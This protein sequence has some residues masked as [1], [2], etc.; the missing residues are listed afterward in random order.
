M[1][2]KMKT[3]SH[4]G[5]CESCR[6][7]ENRETRGIELQCS[8]TQHDVSLSLQLKLQPGC[9]R[10]KC[11]LRKSYVCDFSLWRNLLLIRKNDI[12]IIP[13]LPH[14]GHDGNF[15]RFNRINVNGDPQPG[16]EAT[17]SAGFTDTRCP[18]V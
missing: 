11:C 17:C 16:S 1:T 7:K 6:M 4:A 8:E 13:K 9:S 18:F 5:S 3:L 10:L 15:S 14:R 2:I 12:L